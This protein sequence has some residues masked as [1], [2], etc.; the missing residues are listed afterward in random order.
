MRRSGGHDWGG[1]DCNDPVLYALELD[2]L[3]RLPNVH[4]EYTVRPF[5]PLSMVLSCRDAER[6]VPMWVRVAVARF[7]RHGTRLRELGRCHDH[8]SSA[9]WHASSTVD[10]C[11]SMSSISLM[12]VLGR[13]TLPVLWYRERPARRWDRQA[14]KVFLSS[15]GPCRARSRLKST[16]FEPEI[17]QSH[18]ASL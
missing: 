16:I 1:E 8:R 14:V 7:P 9:S 10:I 17:I 18:K 11:V 12:L 15:L 13:C 2:T 6:N 4:I 5:H 3:Y